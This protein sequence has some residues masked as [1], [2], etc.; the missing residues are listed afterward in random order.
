M[1]TAPPVPWLSTNFK[2]AEFL[3]ADMSRFDLGIETNMR[4]YD[5]LLGCVNRIIHNQWPT[6]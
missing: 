5:E 4:D 1:T 6:L 3:N 2:K